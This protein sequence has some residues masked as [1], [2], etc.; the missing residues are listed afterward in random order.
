MLLD[1]QDYYSNNHP[2]YSIDNLVV[3]FE[4]NAVED[5]IIQIFKQYLIESSLNKE[6]LFMNIDALIERTI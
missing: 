5:N 3:T 6:Q 1:I 2:K 4:N